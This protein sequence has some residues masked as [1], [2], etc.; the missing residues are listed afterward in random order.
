VAIHIE[1]GNIELILQEEET[2]NK[3]G[4]TFI[5]IEERYLLFE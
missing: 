4:T 2:E 5:T 1:E 3:E